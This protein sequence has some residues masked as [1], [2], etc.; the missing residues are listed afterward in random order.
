MYISETVPRLKFILWYCIHVEL[1]RATYIE[2]LAIFRTLR[3][4]FYKKVLI[5]IAV[6]S[7]VYID[8]LVTIFNLKR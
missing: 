4:V 6:L 7:N 8:S 1:S 2:S 5:T 3:R